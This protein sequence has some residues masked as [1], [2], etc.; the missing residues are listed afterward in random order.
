MFIEVSNAEYTRIQN[1]IKGHNYKCKAVIRKFEKKGKKGE[2]SYA[3]Q[4]RIKLGASRLLCGGPTIALTR[5]RI[6]NGA[7]NR[8]CRVQRNKHEKACIT[9]IA[10]K[11]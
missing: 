8:L 5:Q 3:L 9:K 6:E 1:I 7:R 10:N 2:K 11:H 4:R